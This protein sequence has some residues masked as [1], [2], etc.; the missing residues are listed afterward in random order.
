MRQ[1]SS[2]RIRAKWS[3]IYGMPKTPIVYVVRKSL[4]IALTNVSNTTSLYESRG[5]GFGM[6]SFSPLPDSYEPTAS[7][8]GM[9]V[10]EALSAASYESLVFAGLGEPTL[11]LST[12]L[13]TARCLKKKYSN[14]PLRLNTN[15]NSM[16][17]VA[18]HV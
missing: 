6:N 1:L 17:A 4:Y 8:I 16:S 12:L 3:N 5:A 18:M 10:D 11:R 14:L 2:L 7:E 13:E 9:A 15:G